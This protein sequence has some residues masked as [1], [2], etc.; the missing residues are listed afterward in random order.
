MNSDVFQAALAATARIA[1]CAVL[2][3][4]QKT[5]EKPI[6]PMKEHAEQQAEKTV[7]KKQP[8]AKE[9]SVEMKK[10][11]TSASSDPMKTECE[12]MIEEYFQA[13]TNDPSVVVSKE[14]DKCCVDLLV[15][16]QKKSDESLDEDGIP[17]SIMLH[18]D[19][20][21]LTDFRLRGCTPWGPPMPPQVA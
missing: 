18:D 6:P 2:V 3:S 15:G 10:K 1:C 11:E 13:R 12:P 9:A 16:L 8:V 20:C 5:P 4:C 14:L 21:M 19:C 17:Q 7:E